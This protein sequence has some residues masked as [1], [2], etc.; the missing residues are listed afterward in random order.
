M[1]WETPGSVGHFLLAIAAMTVF[2]FL[3]TW[4]G[5]GNGPFP[6]FWGDPIPFSEAL[7]KLPSI[8]RA[9]IIVAF[10]SAVLLG[11][12]SDDVTR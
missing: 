6:K 1:R 7:A 4:L 3:P 2:L 8:F 9:V 5:Y 10:V 12:R 11:I